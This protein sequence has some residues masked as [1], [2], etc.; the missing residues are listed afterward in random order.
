MYAIA[1]GAAIVA[2]G[3]IDKVGTVSRDYC[4]KLVNDPRHLLI[5]RGDVLPV[6]SSHTF[7]LIE[8]C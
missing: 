8:Y 1:E 6:T 5:R 4:I 3:R 7:K 2:A